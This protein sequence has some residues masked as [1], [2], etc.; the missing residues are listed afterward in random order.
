MKKQIYLLIP[1]LLGIVFCCLAIAKYGIYNIEFGD[2]NDYINAANSFLNGTPYPLQSEFHPMFRPPMFSYL[3]AVVWLI[4]PQSILAIKFTQILLHVGTVII[5]YKTIYEILKKNTP[6]FFGAFIVAINPLLAAHTVDFYTEPLHTFLCI[7]AMFLLVKMLKADRFMYFAAFYAGVVFGLATLTRPAILGVAVLSFLVVAAVHLKDSQRFRYLIASAI[8]FV[9]TFL[10][11]LPWTYQNYKNT[12]EFILVNDGFSYNL[13]LGNLP[14]TIQL[15]E[16]EFKTKEENQAFAD[17]YW[18]TVQED[19]LKELQANDNYYQ[20]KINE[21]EKV[22]RR[23]A[24]ANMT[25]D[26]NLTAR[27]FVG[28]FK[29]FWTPFLNHFTYGKTVVNLVAL[30]VIF[31]YIF[32]LYGMYIFSKDKIGKNYVILLLVTF[33]VTTAIHVLIFGFVRYRVPNVDP[34]LSMLS[35]VA[36][37]QICSKFL[38]RLNS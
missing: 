8:L 10:T 27:L 35:G 11:I 20:L 4:F 21:R 23:E 9:S 13:W 37:W 26:Y 30:F 24:L 38:P 15:Y 12:G 29:A 19:K 1:I 14:G 31:T 18:G 16:G 32:G 28:K 3:I 25:A 33:A 2:T 17:Y 22:W 7:L 34:Y 5:A 36:V 6:A